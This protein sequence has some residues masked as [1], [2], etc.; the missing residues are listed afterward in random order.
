MSY[1]AI[2]P[3]DL[4]IYAKPTIYDG[5]CVFAEQISTGK[6]TVL[7]KGHASHDRA[8]REAEELER[9]VRAGKRFIRMWGL[10]KR[11]G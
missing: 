5:F 1:K 7:V 11:R 6:Q 4:K 10:K 2:D 8:I 3:D 9:E